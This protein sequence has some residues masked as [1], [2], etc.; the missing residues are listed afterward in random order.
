MFLRNCETFVFGLGRF[1]RRS[2]TIRLSRV[3]IYL[4]RRL[5]RLSFLC[6]PFPNTFFVV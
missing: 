2:Q 5:T 1:G 4:V 6:H 3:Q